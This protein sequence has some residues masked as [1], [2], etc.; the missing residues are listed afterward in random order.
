MLVL[1]W[2]VLNGWNGMTAY[3]IGMLAAISLSGS[4]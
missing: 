4:V 3:M 1:I 2:T